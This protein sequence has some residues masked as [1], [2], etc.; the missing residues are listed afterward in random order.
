MLQEQL[1]ATE[2]YERKLEGKNS[3]T[4]TYVDNAIG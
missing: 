4:I 3:V 2:G 1:T